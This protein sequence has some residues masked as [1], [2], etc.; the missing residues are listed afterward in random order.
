M[1]TALILIHRYLGIPLSFVFVVWF[2]SGIVM[3]YAGGMPSLAPE[4]RLARLPPLDLAHVTLAPIEAASRAESGAGSVTLLSVLGRP[5]YRFR[6]F[7]DTTVFADDSAILEPVDVATARTIASRFLE[8]PEN[9]IASVGIVSQAD[10]W[11]LTLQRA[12]PLYKFRVID[13][14]TELYV[15][16]ALAEVV[17]VT[18]RATRV[19]AWAGTIP[20]WF[21]VT[22]LR[23]NQPLWYWTVVWFS[24]V[25][26]VL[27]V[28]GLVLAVVQ[29]RPT[30]PFRVGASIPY[31]GS[32][33]WHYI[34]G[35]VF[36]VFTLTWVFSGLMS[37]EPFAWTRA[38]GLEVPRNVLSGGP[39][40]LEQFPPFD[41]AALAAALEG[42]AVKELELL[43][44]Q[45]EPYYLARLASNDAGHGPE[46]QHQPYPLAADGESSELLI[47]A[48]SLHVRNAPF[49]V[50]SLLA[51]LQA[52]LP[53]TAISAAELLDRYDSYYYARG[54]R[55]PL[56]VLRVKF[57]DP[58]ETWAYIDPRKSELVGVVHNGSRLERWLFNGLHSLD[59]AF[60]WDRRPLWDIGMI[61]LSLGALVSSGIGVYL[62]IRRVRRDFGFH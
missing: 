51:R 41:G 42:R 55:A 17:L 34:T 7:A 9:L 56:P 35:A 48:G 28:L 24:A 43:R 20:H 44:I 52:G 15:S 47:S 36:G 46:R 27:A 60:W 8:V 32:M 22:P 62:G 19:L 5:A 23:V 53:E 18:T 45:D 2:V 38:E 58:A 13:A 4:A 54:D 1:R 3:M 31:R 33:R 40:D 16:P 25:G 50:E 37:M 39:L 21:Y 59:F 57:A 49:S 61:A 29:F 26:C 14:T 6:G 11:T 10:Q 30:R 12:L